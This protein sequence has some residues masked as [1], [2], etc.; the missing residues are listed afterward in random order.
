[1]FSIW[2]FT[3]I[4]L[5]TAIQSAQLI[6]GTSNVKYFQNLIYIFRNCIQILLLIIVCF[7][8]SKPYKSILSLVS[9]K[10]I[11]YMSLYPVIAFLLLITNFTT[12]PERLANFNSIYDMLLFLVFIILG[13]VFVFAGISSASKIIS[14]QYDMEKLELISKTD[15]LTGLLNRRNI[16]E[17]IE[18]EIVKYKINKIK[19]ALIIA[20]IDFF[21]KVND[22]FGHDCGDRVLKS[23]SKNLQDAVREQMMDLRCQLL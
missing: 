17:K 10:T 15:P 3:T 20:D 9:D 8:I 12:S 18:N 1:M 4:A 5:L 2:L 7:W 23:I 11:R 19:F 16:I 13:Y 22:T 14:L 21:K 6:S